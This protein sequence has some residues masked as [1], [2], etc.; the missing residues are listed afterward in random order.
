MPRAKFSK[1]IFLVPTFGLQ[2]TFS[3][4]LA[5]ENSFLILIPYLV[6]LEEFVPC[7]INDSLFQSDSPNLFPTDI[8]IVTMAFQSWQ[9]QTVFMYKWL[10]IQ[11]KIIYE[12]RTK[13]ELVFSKFT[14]QF[15]LHKNHPPKVCPSLPCFLLGSASWSAMVCP[16]MLG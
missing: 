5:A 12:K 14:P 7:P 10:E 6:S 16:K 4:I 13:E 11:C 8:L 9:E 3:P 15:E 2:V 1:S